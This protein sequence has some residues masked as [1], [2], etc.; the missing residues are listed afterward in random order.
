LFQHLGIST[1]LQQYA[2]LTSWDSI[3]G[4][5]IARVASA[6][7]IDNGILYVDVR[8]ASWRHELTMRKQ[9][10]LEKIHRSIGKKVLKDIR[11]H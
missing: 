11:F 2:V 3:V 5:Q 10:I 6:R 4:E 9:E 8:S 7:K 1:R